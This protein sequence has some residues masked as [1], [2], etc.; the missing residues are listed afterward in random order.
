MNVARCLSQMIVGAVC[1][2]LFAGA[3]QADEARVLIIAPR[4][5]PLVKKL[6]AELATEHFTIGFWFDSKTIESTAEVRAHAVAR[7]A[8]ILLRTSASDDAVEVWVADR[9]G[10]IVRFR[11]RVT[12]SSPA[13]ADLLAVHAHEVVRA[14]LLADTSPSKPKPAPSPLPD[15]E[16]PEPP[17]EPVA[18]APAPP[19]VA[20]RVGPTFVAS[21]ESGFG[22][23]NLSLGVSWLA[24]ERVSLDAIASLPIFASTIKA[25]EGSA[26]VSLG[27][28][29]AGASWSPSDRAARVRPSL[30]AGMALAWTH[31]DGIATPPFVSNSDDVVSFLPYVDLAIR[32]MLTKS[33]AIGAD[34]LGGV[35]FPPARISF[36]GHE[37]ATFGR[38][39]MLATSSFQV[40][41]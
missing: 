38:P 17:P 13:D 18:E 16:E 23:G 3:A 20:L 36:A 10:D 19:R 5:T 26:R 2:L 33:L 6:E 25:P 32:V 35:A 41:W 12:A 8:R 28:L 7:E 21:L 24:S 4:A 37:V 11:E 31:V 1:T 15:V 30:G 40:T 14:A 9:D 29:G 27:L 34:V 39:M 22:M